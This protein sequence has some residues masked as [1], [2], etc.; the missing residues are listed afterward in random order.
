MPRLVTFEE[1]EADKAGA[2]SKEL[3]RELHVLSSRNILMSGGITA[4]VMV[5][6][7]LSILQ[8]IKNM[9]SFV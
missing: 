3:K 6:K 4:L 9:I 1:R 8:K 7:I 5:R 2:I